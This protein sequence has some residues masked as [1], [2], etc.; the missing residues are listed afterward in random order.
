MIGFRLL[1]IGGERDPLASIDVRTFSTYPVWEHAA[2]KGFVIW[3]Y[4]PAA[5]NHCVPFLLEAFP[6][7]TVVFNHM[8]FCPGE[9]TLLRAFGADRLM[10][11]T[12]S[13]WIL[14]DPG[15]ASLR[16]VIDAQ[17]PDLSETERTLIMGGTAQAQLFSRG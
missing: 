5:E 15:Y 3:L 16:K 7:L 10:W 4:P 2:R 1:T 17:L 8:A 11:A 6:E 12:D 14:E 9:G 13:P